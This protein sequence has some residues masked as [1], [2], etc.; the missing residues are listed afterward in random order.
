MVNHCGQNLRWEDLPKGHRFF[1]NPYDRHACTKCPKCD[2]KTAVRKFPLVIRIDPDQMLVLNKQ[3]RYCEHCDLVIVKQ[4]NL[5]ALMAAGLEQRDAS[6]VGNKY[7][8][9]GTLSRGDWRAREQIL[10]PQETLDR[11]R[12][13]RDVWT[14]EITGGWQLD[15]EA[16]A[17]HAK[18]RGR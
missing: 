12:V 7:L 8:V 9:I 1:L 16:A 10:T 5:E 2:R 17:R 18:A 4:S 13:F 3:C 14:F 15:P 6:I 11:T